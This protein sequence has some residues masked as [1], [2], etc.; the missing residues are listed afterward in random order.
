MNKFIALLIT[1]LVSVSA[2][3]CSQEGDWLERQGWQKLRDLDTP[4]PVSRELGSQDPVPLLVVE[5]PDIL[6]PKHLIA[7]EV[8]HTNVAGSGFIEMWTVYANDERY[9]SRTLGHHGPM[10]K[11]TGSS[12]WRRFTLP[13]HGKEDAF[14][15]R[16]E[17][18]IILPGGGEVEVRNLALYQS[19]NARG[20]GWWSGAYVGWIGGIGG[21]CIGLLG[22]L[23]G[24]LASL[25]KARR[26]VLTVLAAYLI[27]GICCLLAGTVA[28]VMKQPFEVW[29]PLVLFGGILT[30]CGGIALPLVRRAY[31]Q[32]ELRCIAAA[33]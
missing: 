28:V 21:P 25:G 19:E 9:F 33:G 4:L 30:L 27:V 14:P 13:F 29:Y 16:L 22:G 3:G 23:C 6:L 26:F 15:E 8:R 1:A 24:M 5:T 2:I 32:R 20:L 7:G 12:G 10:A 11:M 31:I 17:A 18:N